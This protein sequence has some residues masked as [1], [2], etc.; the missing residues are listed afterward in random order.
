LQ[1]LSHNLIFSRFQN[2]FRI[3]VRLA[4]EST[5]Q[6]KGHHS[7]EMLEAKQIFHTILSSSKDVSKHG[8]L[9]LLWLNKHNIE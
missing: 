7:V 1:H 5:F 3:F 6:Q 9:M 4:N 8:A 2:P